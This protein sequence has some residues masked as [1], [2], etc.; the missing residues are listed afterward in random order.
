[1]SVMKMIIVNKAVSTQMEASFAHVMKDLCWV[2]TTF[3]VKVNMD[4]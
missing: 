4:I 3:P 1:M 2:V